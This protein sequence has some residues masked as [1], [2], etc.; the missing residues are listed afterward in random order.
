MPSKIKKKL[1][2]LGTSLKYRTLQ[3]ANL[4]NS[5]YDTLP[6]EVALKKGGKIRRKKGGKI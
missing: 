3:G 1:K 2:N 5:F 4:I 6:M